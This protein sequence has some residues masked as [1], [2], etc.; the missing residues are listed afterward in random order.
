MRNP[1][2]DT[3]SLDCSAPVGLPSRP[4]S[5][6]DLEAGSPLPEEPAARRGVR[7]CALAA[8]AL[9]VLLPARLH[10]LDPRVAPAQYLHDTWGGKDGLPEGPV[11]SLLCAR[12]G[13]L[14]VGSTAGLVRFDGVR[15]TVF[16]PGERGLGNVSFARRLRQAG[17]GAIWAA[18]VGG[19]A[20]FDGKRFENFA[21]GQG[22][23]HPFVYALADAARDRALW[24]GTGGS[25]VW[26]LREGAFTRHPAYAAETQLPALVSD[27]AVDREG[28][29]WVAT[30]EGLL[31]LGARV[32][33]YGPADG[34]ASPVANT[35]LVDGEGVLWVGT[36]GG[37]SRRTGGRFETWTTK[38]GLSSD[39]VTALAADEGGLWIGTRTAG[40]NRLRGATIEPVGTG[41]STDTG[42]LALARGD[43]GSLWVGTDHGLER[44]RQGAFR[45][46]GRESGL[47]GERILNVTSRAAGGVW[48][49]DGTGALATLDEGGAQAVALPGTIQEEGMVP[50]V[51][52][53]DGSLWVGGAELR[54]FASGRWERHANPGGSFSVL[55]PDGDGLLVAQTRADGTSALSRFVAGRFEPVARELPL[56][57]VQRLL[58]D[59]SG[60]LWIASGGGLVRVDASGSR[61]FRTAD[62]LPHDT[63]YGLVEDDA[64]SLWVGTR[65][66]L[67]R[68]RGDTVRSLA[69]VP[70][71][72]RRA[73]LH[74]ALDAQR[75][76]W[77][78]AEDGVH[79]LKLAD[80]H[81]LAD[82]NRADVPV[83][84]YTSADGLRGLEFSWR[85]P[86]HARTA[87]GRLWFATS[88]G[89]SVVDP[90]RVPLD[91]P[92]PEVVVEEVLLGGRVVEP[93]DPVRVDAASRDRLAIRFTA[94][95]LD[96]PEQLRFR[97]RLVGYDD[98]WQETSGP[99][100][101][102]FTGVPPGSYAFEAGAR[103]SEGTWATR[104]A[105]LRLE[106]EPR[107]Y[108]SDVARLA[109]LVAVVLALAGAHRL[110]LRQARHRQRALA[111]LVEERTKEL[112]Q[113]VGERRRAEQAVRQ[114]NAELGT[115][116]RERTAELQTANEALAQEKE[117]LAVTL[118]SLAEA[119]VTTDVSGRVVLM[120]P[121]AERYTGRSAEAAAGRPLDEVLRFVGRF[122]RCPLPDPAALVLAGQGVEA[123]ALTRVL[124][125]CEGCGELLVDASAA[126]IRDREDHVVGAVLVLRDVTERTLAE[127]RLRKAQKLESIGVLAGGIAHDFNNLLTGIFGH[128]D[129]AR[130]HLS[131]SPNAHRLDSAL[132]VL[133]AA[134]SLTRQLLT[135][136]A[137]GR[138][139]TEPQE[140]ADLLRRSARFVLSG[141]D[142]EVELHLPDGLW[143]CDIDPLQIRQAIDNVLLNARQAMPAGGR[144][145]IEA[146]NVELGGG[147][148]SG[149]AEGRYVEVAVTDEGE[150]IPPAIRERVFE[151]FFTTKESGTGLGLATVHSIVT[152][153]GGGVRIEE[154][155]NRGITFR[156]HLPV[157]AERRSAEPPAVAAPARAARCRILVMDDEPVLRDI[158]RAALEEEGHE[159]DVVSCGEQA[160]AA[161]ARAFAE[162]R[163]FALAILD[164]TIA[165]GLGGVPTLRRLREITPRL[166]AIA[167]SGY[168]NGPV[169]SDPQAYGFD[170]NLPK[171]YSIAD[172]IEA[173]DRALGRRR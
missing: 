129:L 122:D 109:A 105:V 104:V 82:G 80:L 154:G 139:A 7:P 67:A 71:A 128:V 59:R 115:R 119:V 29:L 87:D 157:A 150:G 32:R 41:P 81:A 18:L 141:T 133:D 159:V 79:V 57:H 146:R 131:E 12:D 11:L 153:H 163:P 77:V 137:G 165:G 70:G 126:P 84:R 160:I 3:C 50:I 151:P 21:D 63:V 127:E 9:A 91:T 89:V 107:W 38:Q 15:F 99:R 90:R 96:A 110:R 101:A 5:P 92:A 98:E 46:F 103:R 2:R 100:V 171:P 140:I 66:G 168:A 23:K 19:V 97:F 173:V 55:Q 75:R 116:V 144:V 95:T 172:I 68:V 74:L 61:V 8:L 123:P 34:L 147:D 169:L 39:D 117:R 43:D 64:G 132:E 54:R 53:R 143:P 148:A 27:L 162:G 102:S 30:S 111:R 42:V 48:V 52:A 60:R 135:F 44:Y 152:Q 166:R 113:E 36:R 86:G 167:T 164:L 51:E 6:L 112:S 120:N 83:R 88:R 31:A 4:E 124:L 25:G 69:E 72:P 16:E 156:I 26:Q 130:R 106:V 161:V 78:A 138:P 14:W 155:R 10:A 142:L 40:L 73:P 56:L 24:V 136:S 118:R 170:G 33:R 121:V 17:D 76:L 58:R 1:C 125:V 65:A 37:L 35:L 108:E 20:R 134:R 94:P 47:A 62:G 145:E 49:L 13:T 28:T 85:P 93:H 45:T 149:L 158:A 114:L 22:L